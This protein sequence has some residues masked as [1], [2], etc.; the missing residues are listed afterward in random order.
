[1]TSSENTSRTS[2]GTGPDGC[3]NIRTSSL[4]GLM[5]LLEHDHLDDV[6]LTLT[7]PAVS[8][9]RDYIRSLRETGPSGSNLVVLRPEI[10]DVTYGDP[11]DT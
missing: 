3:V 10:T 4:A 5:A 8:E 9:L 6:T 2:E 7:P 11:R 1:M